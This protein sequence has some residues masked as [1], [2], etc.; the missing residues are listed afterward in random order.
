MSVDVEIY[1]SNLIKFFKQNPK[2][3]LNLIPQDKEEE[4]YSKVRLIANEN[5]EDGK[6]PALTQKQFIEICKVLNTVPSKE[7]EIKLPFISS[8]FGPI[9]L[10]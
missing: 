1:L 7:E 9:C 2:D 3:L 10:N 4:F 6:D 8:K 5:I